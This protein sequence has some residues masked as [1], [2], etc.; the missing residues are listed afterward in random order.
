MLQNFVDTDDY[1]KY[2][3]IQKVSR[4]KMISVQ[5][6]TIAVSSVF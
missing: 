4:I 1:I 3:K 6:L 5:M 2:I